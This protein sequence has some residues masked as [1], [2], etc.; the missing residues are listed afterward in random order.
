[1]NNLP[2]TEMPDCWVVVKDGRIVGTHDE[3]CSLD[4]VQ[5]V[6]YV[7]ATALEALQ[8]DYSAKCSELELV[9]GSRDALAAKLVPLEA[10]AERLDWL[11]AQG[12]AGLGW[13]ARNSTTGR[14]Y[15]L[16]QDA[17]GCVRVRDAID[18]AKGG[19]H[20]DA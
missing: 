18:A 13:V 5:G 3:P 8:A 17:A 11:Q 1:M 2:L 6:R 10:D 15:R 14:G 19:Q 7:P 9:H 16:H 12:F 20:E 4:G